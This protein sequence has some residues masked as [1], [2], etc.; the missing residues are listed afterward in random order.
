MNG[1][2]ASIISAQRNHFKGRLVESHPSSHLTLPNVLKVAE[3][4][5]I[6]A[7]EIKDQQNIRDGVSAVLAYDGPVV[8]RSMLLRPSDAPTATASTRGDGTL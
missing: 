6:K 8:L 2:Y 1:T 5:G 4:Y 3:A 7:M